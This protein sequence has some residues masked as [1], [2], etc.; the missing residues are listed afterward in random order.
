MKTGK[1][2]IIAAVA[3]LVSVLIPLVA[4]GTVS[5]CGILRK[6]VARSVLE[7][8]DHASGDSVPAFL[9]ARLASELVDA[10]TPVE[11]LRVLWSGS[12]KPLTPDEP[13]TRRRKAS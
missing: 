4:F 1:V 12:D 8:M 5:P 3:V 2:A 6:Q 7:T 10:M 11:C 9:G 13:S